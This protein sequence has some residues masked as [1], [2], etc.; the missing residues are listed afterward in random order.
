[1]RHF[2]DLRDF[3]AD[4]LQMM[5]DHAQ[6]MKQARRDATPPREFLFRRASS[7]VHCSSRLL[8]GVEIITLKSVA[9]DT[10]DIARSLLTSTKV[11]TFYLRTKRTFEVAKSVRCDLGAFTFFV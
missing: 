7:S 9:L 5:L 11:C 4:T 3:S 2:I 6:A 8:V 1:M 10:L